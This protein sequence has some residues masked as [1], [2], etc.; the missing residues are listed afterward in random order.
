MHHEV[1]GRGI[2]SSYLQ[3]ILSHFP[4]LNFLDVYD[5]EKE[6]VNI[7]SYFSEDE[8]LPDCFFNLEFCPSMTSKKNHIFTLP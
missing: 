1:K 7:F 8:Y 2:N 5:S 4:A 6:K 3:S